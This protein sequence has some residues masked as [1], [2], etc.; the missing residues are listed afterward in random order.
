VNGTESL[1]SAKESIRIIDI[2]EA[3]SKSL[4]GKGNNIDI[5]YSI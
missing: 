2:L 5:D 1:S 3:A 4:S